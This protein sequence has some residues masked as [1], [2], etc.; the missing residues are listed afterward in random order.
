MFDLKF[1]HD[2]GVADKGWNRVLLLL[3]ML[4]SPIAIADYAGQIQDPSTG[5]TI[6]LERDS[7]LVETPVIGSNGDKYYRIGNI[8]NVGHTGPEVEVSGVVKCHGRV[9][10]NTSK[11]I[12]AQNAFHR[13][14]IYPPKSGI[15]IEGKAAYQIHSNLLMTIDTKFTDWV[16]GDAGL[17]SN[18]FGQEIFS[19]SAFTTYFPLGITFYINEKIIDSQLV[20]GA[21]DLAGYVRAFTAKGEAPPYDDWPINETTTPLRL[22]SSQIHIRSRCSTMASTGQ[23]ET[24]SLSHGGLNS[25]NYDSLVTEKVIYTCRFTSG[26]KVRLRLDYAKDSDPQ[27]R[28]PLVSDEN[29]SDVIYSQ[30]TLTDEASGQTG[31]SLQVEFNEQNIISIASHI[32][33]ENAVAGNYHGSAWLIATYE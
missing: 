26:T 25:I 28:L 10:G 17:C 4:I 30:L 32:K 31:Q 8:I 9:W 6:R 2:N 14:F 20:I 33:G 27:K 16:K 23:T 24:V 29:D 7:Q 18:G 15:T 21:M 19:T 5:Y 1:H 22:A 3:S 11:P 13:L 12:P